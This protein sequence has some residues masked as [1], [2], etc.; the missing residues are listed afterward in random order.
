MQNAKPYA[1][2]AEVYDHVMGHIDFKKWALFIWHTN[3]FVGLR[4]T[5]PSD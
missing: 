3:S 1:K 4:S 2:F 5:R